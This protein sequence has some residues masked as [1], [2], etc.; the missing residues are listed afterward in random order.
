MTIYIGFRKTLNWNFVHSNVNAS[1]QIFYYLRKDLLETYNLDPSQCE[2]TRLVAQ[3]TTDYVATVAELYFVDSLVGILYQDLL[4]RSSPIYR[5]GDPL[6]RD[7]SEQIDP[8]IVDLLGRGGGPGKPTGSATPT[9]GTDSP[10]GGNGGSGND[11]F[12]NNNTG[13]QSGRQK[14]TTAGIAVGAFGLSVMYGAAMFIVAR[15]YKRK[16]QGH[17]R[18]SSVAGSQNSSEMRY[19][20]A[21]SP[22]LMGGALLSRD[23]SNYGGAGGRNS[24]GS[25]RS[26][27]NSGRTA[28]ISAP[29]AAENSLGWN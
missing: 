21:G 8:N 14:A 25:G 5:N 20:A 2:V 29:V 26:G 10:G 24:H 27:A 1:W 7:L 15:R 28:N 22:A 6:T 17:R 9:G 11:A 18:S 3:P 19:N 4:V 23:L 16:R 13:D 12:D